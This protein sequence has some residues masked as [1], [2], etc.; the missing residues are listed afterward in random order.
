V[1]PHRAAGYAAVTVSPKATGVPPGDISA[2]Q[3]DAVADLADA[4]GHGELRISHE[5]NLILADVRKGGL[6]TLWR[7]LEMLRLATPDVGLLSNIISCPAGDFC[8]LANAASIP[9][10]AA[11]QRRFEESIVRMQVGNQ[12]I[13][14]FKARSRPRFKLGHCF[15]GGRVRHFDFKGTAP[16]IGDTQHQYAN[17]I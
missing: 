3:M 6:F 9:V 15:A 10:V 1:H 5:Q 12:C 17:R 2:D 16:F 11:I 7:E 14:V 4:H 8:A 13:A